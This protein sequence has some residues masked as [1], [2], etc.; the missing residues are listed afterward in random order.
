MIGEAVALHL[1]DQWWAKEEEKH[2]VNQEKL[3]SNQ[4][5]KESERDCDLCEYQAEGE[6]N[7]TEHLMAD[8]VFDLE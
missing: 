1:F 5:K 6:G 7:L 3:I 2:K 4:I 8:H